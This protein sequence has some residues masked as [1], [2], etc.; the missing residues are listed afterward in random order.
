MDGNI[1]K[2]YYILQMQDCEVDGFVSDNYKQK[3][4]KK[5]HSVM[6]I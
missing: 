6:K 2:K 1:L 4:Q 5:S 3:Y